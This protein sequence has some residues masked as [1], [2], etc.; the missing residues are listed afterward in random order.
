M[1]KKTLKDSLI[2]AKLSESQIAKAKEVN[3]KRKQITYALICGS[4]GKIFG[5]EK[6]CRKYFSAWIKV[7]PLIFCEATEMDNFKINDYKSDFNLVN[8]LITIHDPLEHCK[9]LKLIGVEEEE[10]NSYAID[11][12][13]K[14]NGF[15]SKFFNLFK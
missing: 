13:Q 12:H 6:H 2:L 14:Q 10:Y 11:G 8:K 1:S 15:I 7:F 9:K 4:Y 5:T 3:G